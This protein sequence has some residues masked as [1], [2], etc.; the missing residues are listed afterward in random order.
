[1]Y[2]LLVRRTP[3]EKWSFWTES[4]NILIIVKNVEVVERYGWQWKVKEVEECCTTN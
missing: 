4:Q 2:R 3:C 1:M